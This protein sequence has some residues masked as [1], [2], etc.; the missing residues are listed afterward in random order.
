[1]VDLAYRASM[2][3]GVSATAKRIT[4]A[5]KE[6]G[7][8]VGDTGKATEESA[9][10]V[11]RSL[12]SFET[13]TRR[14][15][16]S[17]RAAAARS[18]ADRDLARAMEAA[19]AEVAKGLATREQADKLIEAA[20]VK[21]TAY[22][23]GIERQ[24]AAEQRRNAAMSGNN[25]NLTAQ[26]RALSD[27][28]V[29]N[30]NV[31][32]RMQRLGYIAGQAGFQ[33][34]DFAVQVAGG[35][36]A[37][38][39]F[40]Q[41]APQLL[42]IFG[43]AGA[44]A[45][46]GVAIGA[47]TANLLMGGDASKKFTDA[48]E[49]QDAS[50]RRA[51][52]AAERWRNGMTSE[53]QQVQDLKTYYQGL[54]EERRQYE[55]ILVQ[56]TEAK[57]ASARDS[58][59]QGA[60]GQFQ[61]QIE[62]WKQQIDDLRSS[63]LLYPQGS[64]ERE[65]ILSST[66][67][68]GMQ[69]RFAQAQQVIRD[70]NTTLAAGTGD[71]VEA[72][73]R[74]I[75]GLRGIAETA[76]TRTARALIAM[77]D[78]IM[79]LA[80][81]AE[82]LAKGGRDLE[83]Q[84]QALGMRAREAQE[85]MAALAVATERASLAFSDAQA[86]TRRVMDEPAE[87]LSRLQQITAAYRE[88][89]TA[90]GDALRT[91]LE[92][93]ASLGPR[94]QAQLDS[95]EQAIKRE[96]EAQARSL[97]LAGQTAEAQEVLRG[98]EARVL[99]DRQQNE[100]ALRQT[101]VDSD[102]A[103]RA[104]DDARTAAR[105]RETAAA[106]A[107]S[108]ARR[109]ALRDE[110]DDARSLGR[111]YET[112]RLDGGTGLLYGM[113][114]DGKAAQEIQRAL[115]N[116]MFDPAVRKKAQDQ[117][118]RDLKASQERQERLIERS[119]DSV[120]DYSADTFADLFDKNGA[121]WEGM[122]DTF[123]TTFRRTMARIAA[124]AIIRPIISPV[125]SS[126]VG[127][128]SGSSVAGA[129]QS[130]SGATGILGNMS[131]SDYAG[132][133]MKLS[134][135]SPLGNTGFSWLDEAL[136]TTVWESG[137]QSALTNQA[138]A[139][140]GGQFGPATP[141]AVG[142]N[143][144]SVG[145]GL[146]GGASIVGGLYGIYQG[147]QIGG[148]K[149]WATS[150]AGAAGAIG[151]AAGLASAAGIGGAAMAGI[152]TVAPYAAAV[153]AIASMFLDGQK[154]SDRTGV[155]RG[156]LH[157]DTS[158]V[159]G[160]NGDRYSQQNRD[161]AQQIGE[162]VKALGSTLR[163]ALGVSET[164]F[165]YEIA[166]GDR[167]GMTASYF[168]GV[169]RYSAD[170]AGSQQLVQD[171]T[172]ALVESMRGLASAEVQSV[173]GASGTDVEAL[174]NNLD[175]YN[176]TYKVMVA[177]SE[178]PTSQYQQQMNAVLAPIDAAI[179]KARE[180]GLS[181]DKLNE[182]R[183]KAIQTLE[184]QRQATL[185]SIALNDTQRQALAS[186]RSS[187][188]VALD[189]WYGNAKAETDALFEQLKQ[190]GLGWAEMDPILRT[191][192]Q[193][194]EAE[195]DAASSQIYATRAGN[196]GSLW[197]RIAMARGEP[198]TLDGELAAYDRKAWLE[199]YK[200]ERDGI[201][202]LTLLAQVQAEERLKIE[203]DYA[204]KAAA[205]RQTLEDRIFAATTD[206]STLQGQLL[207]FDRQAAQERVEMAKQAGG[208]LVLL[209]EAL[210]AERAKIIKD[211]AEQEKQALL[212]LGGSIR[213]WI[214]SVRGSAN[215]GFSP[216]EQL[217]AAQDAFGRDL[218]LA[219]GGDQEAL[220]R[221]T[222]SADALLNAGRGMYASGQDFTTLRDWVLSSM[223]NLPTVKS[224]DQLILEEL[225]KLGGAVNVEVELASFRVITEQLN[226]LTESERNQLVQAETVLR[227]VE[228]RLGRAL[229]APERLA[230]IQSEAILRSVEQVLGRDLTAAERAGLVESASV[231]RSIQQ[232]IGRSLTAA[233]QASL[234]GSETILRSVEQV[235]GRDLTAAERTGLV[236][237]GTVL[238]SIQQAIGRSLTAAEQASLI[239]SETVLRSIQQALGRDLT[240][241][242]RSGLV[243]SDTVRRSIEQAIGR[244]LTAAEQATLV[245]GST[246]RRLVEQAMGRD[247]TATERSGLV[248][249]GSVLRIVEQ[250]MGRSL[251]A[252]EQATLIEGSTVRRLIEQTLGRDLTAAERASLVNGGSVLRIVE[253]A[254]GRSL[255]AAEQATLIE[256]STVRRLIEQALGRDLTAEERAG[257]VQTE[258][259]LRRVEQ[260]LGRTLT[261]A[262]LASL[263]QDGAILRT[264]SQILNP[265][266]PSDQQALITGGTV[267]RDVTQHVETTETVQISRSID[268]KLS[269]LLTAQLGLL[270]D[271]RGFLQR[272]AG[273]DG[274][275]TIR[276]GQDAN[277]L[278]MDM[279]GILV[280]V[281]RHLNGTYG[282]IGI[283]PSDPNGLVVQSRAWSHSIAGAGIVKFAMG[284][285]L[286]EDGIL[287]GP[288]DYTLR[289]GSRIQ[290]GEAGAEAILPLDRGPDGRLGVKARMPTLPPMP[291]ASSGSGNR[292]LEAEV[293]G[294]R[295]LV[296]QLARQLAQAH[297][298]AQR[299]RE[300]QLE[301]LEDM[302]DA[303]QRA[304]ADRRPV[305]KRAGAR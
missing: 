141:S 30:D 277:A 160:L 127:G 128:V 269:G 10:K 297:G 83:M 220:G 92:A 252:A 89:G 82:Q 114:A 121:G 200:A 20:R 84:M 129:S 265:L 299:T 22:V 182:V 212:N 38:V 172:Q 33:I 161:R 267:V 271:M 174:L 284:G 286:G 194:L 243:T 62:V 87:R 279:R 249:G 296:A 290:V 247:L 289:D 298:Q 17:A 81:E 72:S 164:P 157:T 158:E 113:E 100:Q 259:V 74:L 300:Q 231:L 115:K 23:A 190:L 283:R 31:A 153:L 246:V 240:A 226:A 103:E 208:D 63:A 102:K 108:E 270:S 177:E 216:Q 132:I 192:W 278:F 24:I 287:M 61:R 169:R 256:G 109:K 294:L 19:N 274:G 215:A 55:M 242:E 59:S 303:T 51:T 168:G 8:A 80:P 151:G 206:T 293:R 70:F 137:S 203:R 228:E 262:E 13:L 28:G 302:T 105:E 234:I 166:V 46:A 77:S 138:L 210:A 104:L 264:I 48:I 295:E 106:R 219:R 239:G 224:Y 4:E 95:R 223:E 156:N 304:A 273:A 159:D 179:S 251:T 199:F 221:I 133:G 225:Q 52:E 275:V 209:E 136:A 173:I 218:A 130:A 230:L 41:Q 91:Q 285:V 1:M 250:T 167:D 135:A 263:V 191:R 171:I 301:E 204:E 152:A 154:P 139:E 149:G 165:N 112:L 37:L 45:G 66:E 144:I 187:Q 189:S 88:N 107:A 145:Q 43:T 14:Y 36:N 134:G 11:R 147:A 183:A 238:R 292:A 288:T 180:L 248:D 258:V 90:A 44:I 26:A 227:T 272:V 40:A 118:E 237:S 25:T 93:E 85:G 97:Q 21:T 32:G 123:E 3:D 99:A 244:N 185:E 235:L 197:D 56:S 142:Y 15:D 236:A 78:G 35:Q 260:A 42:G 110:A 217:Q 196:D 255:T 29:A 181:E 125:V 7:Q 281:D 119:V 39:A 175:W 68:Q 126:A 186:G 2:Q 205:I 202:D 79:K 176:N 75:Q 291:L 18:K 232:A 162:Q 60:T 150:G 257:L 146:A 96:A 253:Q 53:A 233:E 49:A 188:D 163:E 280:T 5:A 101:L 195:R 64:Q 266:M 58:F 6:M 305:G 229:T 193:T 117:I 69:S 201:T 282:G 245:E 65:M 71:A 47:I 116:S 73:A 241:A 50:L 76:D 268:D 211:Y 214:D 111:I 54:S 213:S 276:L 254:L 131:L 122:L 12:P 140:M 120:V 94:L 9:E 148:A 27:Y 98:V 178:N 222:S 155:Y 67:L 184:D 170:E 16:D 198:G 261:A 86:A 143:S 34:Q 57:L 124:E 207:A